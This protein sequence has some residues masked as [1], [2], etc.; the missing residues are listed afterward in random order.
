MIHPGRYT[1][2]LGIFLLQLGFLSFHTTYAMSAR[3]RKDVRQ[4]ERRERAHAMALA[5][6]SAHDTAVI[7]KKNANSLAALSGSRKVQVCLLLALLL[8]PSVLADGYCP[9]GRAGCGEDNMEQGGKSLGEKEQEKFWEGAR[10]IRLE[11]EV[12]VKQ[13]DRA[14]E[15]LLEELKKTQQ[16]N[17]AFWDRYWRKENLKKAKE[18]GSF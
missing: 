9:P 6:L 13:Q 10:K 2:V 5:K 8:V 18:W 7:P 11:H 4:Q 17:E 12:W 14:R 15:V 3:D 16:E 1:F